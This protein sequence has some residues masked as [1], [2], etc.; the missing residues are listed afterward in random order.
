MNLLVG[1]QEFFLSD[2]IIG[3]YGT[4]AKELERTVLGLLPVILPYSLI[5]ILYYGKYQNW[6][7]FRIF[8]YGTIFMNFVSVLPMSYRITYGVIAL[9]LLI[10]PVLLKFKDDKT[11]FVKIILICLFIYSTYDFISTCE[12]A[13]LVPYT[14]FKL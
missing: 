6:I 10:Y 5:T 2:E 7:L 12:R 11:A 14:I 1:L 4:W 8:S 13:K 9:E 3:K